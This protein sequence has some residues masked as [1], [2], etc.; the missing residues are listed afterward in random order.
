MS[1]LM[2]NFDKSFDNYVR[3]LKGFLRVFFCY[4]GGKGKDSLKEIKLKKFWAATN[5]LSKLKC[6][7]H[8][9]VHSWSWGR[10]KEI[11]L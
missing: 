3:L 11:Y 9:L 1:S 8:V 2:K 4:A 10:E 5:H 6:C 7:T